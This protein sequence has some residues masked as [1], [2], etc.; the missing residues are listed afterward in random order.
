[1][2]K[3]K[4]HSTLFQNLI[5]D[6][7][8]FPIEVVNGLKKLDVFTQ[9]LPSN[10]ELNPNFKDKPDFSNRYKLLFEIGRG[11]L[12]VGRIM[13]GHLNA[14]DL[15][16]LFGTKNQ[17]NKYF[18]KAAAGNLFGIWN[19]ERDF[20]SLEMGNVQESYIL[21]GAKIFCSGA[22]N[23]DYP[24]ITAK[25]PNG[26]QLI[27]L[28]PDSKIDLIEDWSLWKP[29][30]MRASV[31]CRID[32]SGLHINE[33]QF[34]G[35]P[36]DYYS[37]PYFSWGATRFCAVQLG[38]AQSIVDIVI[39]E[40]T[41]LERINDPYQNARL[42]KMA[43]LMESAKLW[44][45]KAARIDRGFTMESQK[46]KKINFANMMRT[47]TIDI[48]EEIMSLSEKCLGVQG[49]MVNHPLEKKL[50]D[51]RVYLKQARPDIVLMDVGT[52]LAKKYDMSPK[53]N[54]ET[55]EDIFSSPLLAKEQLSK[56]FGTTLIVAPHPD[57]ES[58]GCGG[59]IQY[60]LKQQTPVFV[61]FI[62]SGEASH[63][64]SLKYPS[65]VL[66]KLR[67]RESIKACKI[68]GINSD[69]I[70]FFRCKD[71][72]LSTMNSFQKKDLILNLG[73][74]IYH[75]NISSVFLPWRRDG[76][77]DHKATYEIGRIAV[78][79]LNKN[80]QI[81]EYPIWLW[82][83]SE[84]QD[85]PISEEVEIF[86]LDISE[87][88]L[89]KRKAIFAHKSQTTN[90]IDDAQGGFLLT[91]DLLSPFLRS[92]EFFFIESRNESKSLNK[93]YF[94]SIYSNNSDPWNFRNSEY[95]N[96]KYE[97]INSFLKDKFFS[98]GLELGC[99][100]GVHTG[101]LSIHCKHLLAVD[102]NENAIKTAI[103]LN[104]NLSNVEFKVEDILINFPEGPFEFISMCEMGYYFT[105][106]KLQFLYQEIY[107][108]LSPNGYFLMVHWLS[109]VREYPLTGRKVRNLFE[110]STQFENFSLDS[111][112]ENESYELALWKKIK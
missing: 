7:K 50:R 48:C 109:F 88:L 21:Q 29:S 104:P 95:E 84:K 41:K 86:R 77:P 75:K 90:L 56:Q 25:T 108:N 97:K 6:E 80:I 18:K 64:Y 83:N 93:E 60:L 24:L 47:A 2:F 9:L 87:M 92:E 81:V 107:K 96:S 20:E 70:T 16:K 72:G 46:A 5:D 44:I 40:L 45:Y 53:K 66:S 19:S 12:S 111:F 85:W 106:E 62:T 27:A 52:Y 91:A 67:E 110:N 89:K 102:I 34:I 33:K 31:S 55:S 57:D 68:L 73:N 100:I 39:M 15:I 51:L 30:G 69:H 74:L 65:K 54:H 28:D 76:H 38:G 105:K 42:G 3:V 35:N 79:E 43:I 78:E 1:M 4:N 63:P 17:I 8:T 26:V 98:Q 103:E 14:L 82:K 71:G 11:D 58:L 23:V 99:S 32:F 61:C 13:E 59:I 49:L 112:Y 36:D 37:E 22:L 101:F 10:H 94:D